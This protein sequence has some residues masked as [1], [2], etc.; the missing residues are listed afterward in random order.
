MAPT[1][2]SGEARKKAVV[3]G[4]GF[5]G[6]EAASALARSGRFEVTLVSDRDFLYLNPI[7]IWIPTHGLEPERARV[8]LADIARKRGFGLVV[9]RVAAIRAGERKVQLADAALEYAYLVVALGG[10]KLQ[11]AGVEKTLS[12]CG[13]PDSAIAIRD[14]LDTL[15]AK[16]SGRIAV[17]FGGNPKDRSAVRG[18]PAFELLFNIDHDL[19][20]RRLRDRFELTFFAPM[21]E[22]G[23][24]MGAPALSLMGRMLERSRISART[25]TP[26]AG[27][28]EGGVAFTDGTRL[29]SDLTL[30][31]PGI[32]GHPVLAASDLPLNEAGFVRIDDHG[33]VEGTDNVYA[34]GDVAALDGPEWRAKQGHTAEVMARNVAANIIAA[35]SGRPERRGYQA[36]LAIMCVLDVGSG[37]ALIYRG[38]RRAIAIP[39]PVV[40]HWMK[41]GWGAYA[42]QT[43]LGRMRRLPGL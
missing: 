23:E 2:A 27:F 9:E 22:P 38:N 19:R 25:G 35:E 12:I 33:L 34:A 42:R 5:A 40:G 26:I 16:G 11:P 8:P 21:A 24:K 20:R 4:G 15:I 18:G 10:S 37:A 1:P 14:R 32:A 30:F 28:D 39:L 41:R 31:V 13:A 43:K 29:D 36:L 6:I 3:L 7:T 17:G